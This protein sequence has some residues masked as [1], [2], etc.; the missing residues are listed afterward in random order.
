MERA[1]GYSLLRT[2]F[3]AEIAETA[4]HFKKDIS[5]SYF[6]FSLRPRDYLRRLTMNLSVAL[7]RRVLYPLVGTPQGVTG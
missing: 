3:T 4:E 2:I 1:T 7:F 6:I 5:F